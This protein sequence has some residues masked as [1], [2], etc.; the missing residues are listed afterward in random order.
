MKIEYTPIG[1][2]RPVVCCLSVVLCLAVAGCGERIE[3]RAAVPAAAPAEV[4]PERLSAFVEMALECAEQEYPN[5]LAHAMESDADAGTPSGLHPAFYGCYDWHSAVHGHWLLARSLRIDELAFLHDRIRAVLDRNLTPEHVAAEVA[6]MASTERG[7]W[8]RPYGLAWL[9][10]LAADLR[11]FDDPDARRWA[12]ALRPLEDV[13]V[14]RFKEWLPKL[15]YPIRTGEH[16]QTAFAFGLALDYAR[17]T[18]RHDL[19]T[20][21]ET[22]ARE[23]HL[24][25]RG[26]DLAFEPS[27]QDFLSPI[28][29]E[30]DLMAR[31]LPPAEFAAWLDAFLPGLPRTGGATWLPLAQVT[32]RRDGKLAHLDGLNLS[33]AWMLRGILEAL[34]ADDPR[35]TALAAAHAE[36][37]T[38]ALDAVSDAEYA[39]GHWLGTYAIYLITEAADYPLR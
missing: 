2:M 4:S 5:N 33:R 14:E 36:H 1:V 11:A 20:L 31:V 18:G 13:C 37:F 28:L 34:P 25:D 12:A 23:F 22:K 32:D 19:A 8:E 39:G 35:R 17:T 3:Q 27:G 24:P 9:L 15:A 30:A 21:I 6:Y 26:A 10:R 38:S 7:S 29:A 16:S